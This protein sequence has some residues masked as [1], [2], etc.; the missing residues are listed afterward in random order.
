MTKM[1]KIQLTVFAILTVISLAVMSLVYLDLPS[2]LGYNRTDVTLEMPDTGGLYPN[3]NVSYLGETIGT[4]DSVSLEPG[5]VR[6]EIHFDTDAH[7]PANVRAAIRSVSAIGEQFVDFVPQ[8]APEGQIEDGTVLGQESMDMPQGVGPVLDQANSLLESVDNLAMRR[9]ID[10]AFLAF[11]GTDRELQELLDSTRLVL[12][13]A[14]QNSEATARLI[15]DAEPVLDSQVRSADAIRSWTRDLAEVA[16]QL[17]ESEPQI[18]SL[19]NQAPETLDRVTVTLDELQPTMPVL[20][21]NL[22]SVGEVG[23]VYNRSIE[24]VLVLYPALV[25]ALVTAVNNG[26]ETDQIKVDFNLQINKTPPCTTGFL[27]AADRRSVSDASVPAIVND[28][29]CKVPEDSTMAVRGARNFPCMEFPD[30]RGASPQQCREGGYGPQHVEGVNPPDT[31]EIGPAPTR[32]QQPDDADRAGASGVSYSGP[33]DTSAAVYDP[34]NGEYI[35]T[36]GQVYRQSDLGRE[37]RTPAGATMTEV[38]TNGV[39]TE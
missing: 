19:L 10:E 24:Q 22:V 37:S 7:V 2:K 20:L 23:V 15:R 13:E 11:N 18:T 32:V 17:R 28:L 39:A 33:M 26:K 6:A 38:M 35:A 34:S 16:E 36:D 3:A 1:V 12:E 27:P 4:V 5:G 30:R 21:A 29:Y 8:G 9:V 14:Q 31:S 25:S